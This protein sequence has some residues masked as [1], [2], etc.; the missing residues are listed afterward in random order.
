MTFAIDHT[1][2]QSCN[3]LNQVKATANAVAGINKIGK[4][5]GI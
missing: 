1:I 4:N 2:K 3:K 5:E